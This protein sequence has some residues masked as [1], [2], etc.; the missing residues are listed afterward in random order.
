MQLIWGS[1]VVLFGLSLVSLSIIIAVRPARAAGFLTLF[2]SS[3]RAHY[4][5]QI[6]R[7]IAGTAILMYSPSMRFSRLFEWLGWLIVITAVALMLVPWRWHHRFG[8]WAI[9]LAIRHLRLYGL[10][11]F[12][13][14]VL[15]LY[16]A[17]RLLLGGPGA[18][19]A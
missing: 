12:A 7:L 16:S 13:F 6:A 9:P 8:Q 1:I 10:V 3:A 15:L 11:V 4:T 5:E 18:P 14:A 2:A 19:S 17:S